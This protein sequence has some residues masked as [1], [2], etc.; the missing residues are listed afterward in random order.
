MRPRNLSISVGLHVLLVLVAVFWSPALTTRL[1]DDVALPIDIITIDDMTRLPS[2]PE[3]DTATLPPSAAPSPAVS[4][5]AMPTR[6]AARAAP[7]PRFEIARPLPVP[8]PNIAPVAR[9]TTSGL[10]VAHI[11]ALLDKT[12]DAAPAP[13]PVQEADAPTMTLGEIDAFRAQMR[14]CWNPPSGAANAEAL[15]VLV[16]LSLTP[17]G[18]IRAG[19]VVVNRAHLDNRYFR[20]AAESVLRAIRRCQPYTMPVEKYESWR[21]MKLTFDPG[22]MLGS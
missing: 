14:K 7:S 8:R 11:Q 2:R 19:P 9:D 6:D 15:V 4:P 16:R 22:R 12:P 3:T 5:D 1:P 13:P 18:H 10:D 17:D 20:A 21:D